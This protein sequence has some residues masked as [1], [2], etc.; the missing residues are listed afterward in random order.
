MVL[1]YPQGVK[2]YKLLD[3]NTMEV[4]VSRDVIFHELVFPFQGQNAS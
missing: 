3:M 1:G 2:G 4:F